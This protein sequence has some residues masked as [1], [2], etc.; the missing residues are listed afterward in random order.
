MVLYANIALLN[1]SCYI[2]LVQV[3]YIEQPV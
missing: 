3:L 1:V 2:H